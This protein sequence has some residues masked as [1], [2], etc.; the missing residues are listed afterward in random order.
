MKPAYDQLGDEYAASSSV[1]IGDADC[2]VEQDLCSDHGV[3]GYPTIK[4]YSAETGKEGADYQGGR[5]FD[6][7]KSWVSEN[8]EA[9]CFIDDQSGCTD[10]EKGYITKMK[11][12]N[13]DKVKAQL[14]R[15]NGMT[16]GSMK[17]ELKAWLMQRIAIL[18]QL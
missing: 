15:L 17:P 9:K 6:D 13:A 18:K 14:D 16:T 7:L 10:K 12:E 1:L 4:Y 8:I 11:A 5:S 2:T 3:R